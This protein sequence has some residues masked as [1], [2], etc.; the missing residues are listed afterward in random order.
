[1]KEQVTEADPCW[2]TRADFQVLMDLHSRNVG[3]A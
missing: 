2:E 3:A 1:M